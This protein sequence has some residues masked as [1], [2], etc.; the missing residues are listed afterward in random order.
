MFNDLIDKQRP[1]E[2]PLHVVTDS[3]PH[4]ES[5]YPK[6]GRSRIITEII[7]KR[8]IFYTVTGVIKNSV[9]FGINSKLS[10]E[11]AST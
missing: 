5:T 1:T 3:K 8:I 9:L 7:P 2:I 10:P 11:N 6:K 4:S